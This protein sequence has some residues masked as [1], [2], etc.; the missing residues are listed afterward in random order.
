LSKVCRSGCKSWGR[1]SPSR[2]SSAPAAASSRPA[3]PARGRALARAIVPA[4]RIVNAL[5][6]EPGVYEHDEQAAGMIEWNDETP[7][8]LRAA[9]SRRRAG[10]P[11]WDSPVHDVRKLLPRRIKLRTTMHVIPGN[12]I[13]AGVT[14]I[15]RPLGF[16]SHH[17]RLIDR[18]KRQAIEHAA[19]CGPEAAA[20]GMVMMRS[21][22]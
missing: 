21:G 19:A 16:R 15:V 3:P 17:H 4:T 9:R 22:E 12:I 14:E 11:S 8:A 5:K 10:A 18:I 7:P 2:T 20:P 6:R 1:C 13:N